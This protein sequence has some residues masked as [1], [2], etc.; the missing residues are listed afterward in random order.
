MMVSIRMEEGVEFGEKGYSEAKW[1]T[2]HSV[3][4]NGDLYPTHGLGPVGNMVDLNRGNRMISLT[5]TSSKARGPA[6]VYCRSG[7]RRPS[8]C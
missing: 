5:S 8:K 6:Q 3:N 1:R 2:G 4:R 7:R